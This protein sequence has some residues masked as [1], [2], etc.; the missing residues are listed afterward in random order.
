MRGHLTFDKTI[1]VF[2]PEGRLNQIGLC[3][4]S[5]ITEYAFKAV[6]ACG[7]TAVALRGGDCVVTCIQKKVPVYFMYKSLGQTR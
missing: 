5:N 7:L 6:A 1:K 4:F 3:I 2:S